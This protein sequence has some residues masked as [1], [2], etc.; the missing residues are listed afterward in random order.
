MH[1]NQD[2]PANVAATRQYIKDFDRLLHTTSTAQEFYAKMLE[3][4]PGRINRGWALWGS[5]RAFKS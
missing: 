5:I 4:H 2:D 3:L 1:E